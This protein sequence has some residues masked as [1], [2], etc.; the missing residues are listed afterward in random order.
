MN[1]KKKRLLVTGSTG[2]VGSYLCQLIDLSKYRFFAIVHS[3]YKFFENS[4]FVDLSASTEDLKQLMNKLQPDIIV[5]LAAMTN[6]DR[7]E[8]ER[9]L[10]DNINH[11]SVRALVNYIVKNKDC[12]LLHVSTDYI[13][14]GAKGNYNESDDPNPINWYGMTKLLGEQELIKCDSKNWCIA[15]TSTPFGMHS[16][17]ISFPLFVIRNLSQKNEINVLTDQTTSPTYAYNLAEMLLEI[18]EIRY[19][20]IVHLSGSSQIS[21]FKQA[22]EI[23][24]EWNLDRSLIKPVTLNEMRWNASRPKNSSLN[25]RKACNTL[26]SKP[27]DFISSLAEF[28]KELS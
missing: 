28:V 1:P 20:G 9:E 6:V 14:D 27:L 2:L 10:A 23:A 26:T 24:S 4:F 25:V 11:L 15:R 7:C 18:I 16:K 3:E 21:R 22:L 8:M 19:S 5:N 12:Y 13:F 17:K